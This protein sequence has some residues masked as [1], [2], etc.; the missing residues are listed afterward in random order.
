MSDL[1][2]TTQDTFRDACIARSAPSARRPR[3]A[4]RAKDDG[5]TAAEYMGILLLVSAILVA[6]FTLAPRHDDQGRGQGRDRRHHQQ[7]QGLAPAGAAAA[8]T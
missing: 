2:T 5:Q 7:R 1:I 3:V 6:I 4:E 8:A